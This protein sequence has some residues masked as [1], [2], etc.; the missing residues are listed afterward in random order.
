M[1]AHAIAAY[2]RY[3]TAEL[4]AL[5]LAGLAVLVLFA[6]TDLDIAAQRPHYHPELSDPWPV[7]HY[8]VWSVLYRA[9]P[10]VTG[11]LAVL[12]AG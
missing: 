1:R 3:W 8:L 6:W 11:S 2:R 7:S 5:G 10:W 4:I 12:G 9:A